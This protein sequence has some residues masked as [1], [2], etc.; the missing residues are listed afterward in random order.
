MIISR[1]WGTPFQPPKHSLR[2]EPAD[3]QKGEVEIDGKNLYYDQWDYDI[4][5]TWGSKP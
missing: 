5:L 1:D 4:E 3:L 2:S